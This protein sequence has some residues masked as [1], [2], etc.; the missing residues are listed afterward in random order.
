MEPYR[1]LKGYIY[2][3]TGAAL[4]STKAI[5]IKLAYREE[6]N[7]SLMLALRMMTALPFFLCVGLYVVYQ[8]KRRGEAMP[9]TP[10]VFRALLTGFLGYYLSALLDFEGLVYITAQLER[11]VLFTYPVFVMF[12]GWLFFGAK[13]TR[14]G[15]VAAAISYAGLLLVFAN[16]LPQGG[17]DTIIGTVLVLGCAVTFAFYQL[18]AKKFIT[19]L[20]SLLFT[21]IALTASG[22]ACITHHIIVSQ[23]FDFS[24]SPRFFAMAAGAGFFA[25]VLPSFLV[26]AGLSRISPQ[27]TSMISTISPIITISLAVAILGEE[28]TFIDATGAALVILGIG[29]YAWT[30]SRRAKSVEVP[31]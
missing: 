13:L 14:W 10:L 6:V 27:S 25:T 30:D 11:L 15:L 23:S 1:T 18:L 16:D 24:A 22:I 12:L 4:F 7:A 5:F 9:D 8:M 3:A 20:G 21:S 19:A 29:V 17:R 28:F 31:A 26:N 2:A